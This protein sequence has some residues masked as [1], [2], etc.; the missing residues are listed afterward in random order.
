MSIGE[1]DIQE[2]LE[3]L[4]AQVADKEKRRQHRVVD[5]RAEKLVAAGLTRIQL[6]APCNREAT[7]FGRRRPQ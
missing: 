4:P 7:S 1:R 2:Y 3:A 5:L 6:K